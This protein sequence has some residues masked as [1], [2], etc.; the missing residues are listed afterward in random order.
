[1][2]GVGR[3]R[4]S[5]TAAEVDRRTTYYSDAL[6]LARQIIAATGR[7]LAAGDR[8]S[9]TFLFRTPTL[10]ESGIRALAAET[11]AGLASVRKGRRQLEGTTLTIN[12]DLVFE[13]D[14][15]RAIGDVKYKL[16]GLE[17]NRADLY[18]VVAFA[19]GF[20]VDRA[21]MILFSEPGHEALPP[22]RIGDHLVTQVCWPADTSLTPD[23]AAKRFA[24]RLR[25]WFLGE[26][27][28]L[29]P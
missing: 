23:G 13:D 16:G 2:D 22:T 12:P 3:L 28:A 21:V 6:G 8:R 5:D 29:R 14:S 25:A 10:V 27:T 18:E 15:V 1:M 24:E 26:E 9:W 11:L 20:R 17:W 4:R 19:A 7:T